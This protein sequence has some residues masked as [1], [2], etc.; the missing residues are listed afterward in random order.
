MTDNLIKKIQKVEKRAII[1]MNEKPKRDFTT[2]ADD[3]CKRLA[4][5]VKDVENHPIRKLFQHRP[6]HYTTRNPST[7]Y[8]SRS[9]T[10]I[11][12]NSFIKY[13]TP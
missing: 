1:F 10:T 2:F 11:R 5:Q 12:K 3:I 7:I 4:T 6:I 9:N 13:L 8:S